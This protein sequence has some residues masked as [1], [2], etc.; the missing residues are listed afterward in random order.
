MTTP[1]APVTVVL[2]PT[3]D[4]VYYY[5]RGSGDDLWDPLSVTSIVFFCVFTCLLLSCVVGD[6]AVSAREKRRTEQARRRY[7]DEC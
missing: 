6:Y 2:V 4:G 1:S 5:R 3:S 7:A